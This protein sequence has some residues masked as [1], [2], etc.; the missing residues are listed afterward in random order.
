MSLD[1]ET[2]VFLV[3]IFGAL[4]AL[5]NGGTIST[6]NPLIWGPALVLNIPF[7]IFN[8]IASAA[9]LLVPLALVGLFAYFTFI[10]NTLGEPFLALAVFGT[11]IVFLGV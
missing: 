11:I 3:F 4:S 1:A 9:P 10:E 8:A 7:A 6:D 5:H 2:L